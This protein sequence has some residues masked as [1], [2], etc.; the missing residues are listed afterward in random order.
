M[1][2]LSPL[3]RGTLI[4]GSQKKAALRFIPAGA[5]NSTRL[6]RPFCHCSVYP[7]WRGELPLLAPSTMYI[8]GLSPLAR[9]TPAECHL[10]KMCFRFIPAGAGNS[11]LS[12]RHSLLPAVYPRWRG[13]L[14]QLADLAVRPA[15][16]SPLARG[17]LA[18]IL[19][20]AKRARFIPAGAGNSRAAM[21][22]GKGKAVYPR[23]RGE[24]RLIM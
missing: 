1:S 23:W 18:A 4:A 8:P 10:L 17:T 20:A 12:V 22:H 5:G 13:E 6:L 11:F 21:L 9:G 7:R 2:G 3:A 19:N 14:E 24:L 15:G 16:L